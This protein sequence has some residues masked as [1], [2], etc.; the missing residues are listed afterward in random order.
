MAKITP[1]N[2]LHLGYHGSLSADVSDG[3]KEPD[4]IYPESRNR[5]RLIRAWLPDAFL[6][7]HGYP[8]HEWVQPFSD[9]TAWVMARQADSGR[10]WWLP[11][12]S[13]ATSLEYMRDADHPYGEAVAYALR[14]RI[15]QAEANVPNLLPL[16]TR[17]N[18]RYERFGQRW[19]PRYM[20]QPVVGGIRFYMA[21]A[22]TVPDS[23]EMSL[24]GVSPDITWDDGYTEAPGRNRARR[25]YEARGFGRSCL[26]HGPP[27]LPCP[28]E[29]ANRA[30]AKG[31]AGGRGV[32]SFEE[33]AYSPVF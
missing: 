22:G 12:G 10:E 19:D 24:N 9:Y 11:R 1:D 18:D 14:D 31:W 20:V 17:M 23:E 25:L 28:R 2:L 15:V 27:E 13:V 4:P 29:A 5:P 3:R 7:P 26:R 33:T 30:N 6:N 16:E 32:E 21:L 8:S